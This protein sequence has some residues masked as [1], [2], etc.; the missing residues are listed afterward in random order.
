MKLVHNDPNCQ[1]LHSILSTVCIMLH[2][3]TRVEC[4]MMGEKWESLNTRHFIIVVLIAISAYFE[5]YS[6]RCQSAVLTLKHLKVKLAVSWREADLVSLDNSQFAHF[7][8]LQNS[9]Q[10]FVPTFFG[11]YFWQH[12]PLEPVFFTLFLKVILSAITICLQKP[13]LHF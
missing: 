12:C 1:I 2:V 3:L 6:A 11:W 4:I 10:Y 8:I 5:I 9:A 7:R 13:H